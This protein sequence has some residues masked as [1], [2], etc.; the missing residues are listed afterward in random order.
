[1]WWEAQRRKRTMGWDLQLEQMWH[2]GR[3]ESG[4][5]MSRSRIYNNKIEYHH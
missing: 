1:M 3:L 2:R 5:T 4:E